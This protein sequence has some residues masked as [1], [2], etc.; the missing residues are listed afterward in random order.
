MTTAAERRQLMFRKAALEK[1]SSP[2]RLDTLMQ[3]TSP[4]GWL[5]IVGIGVVIALVILWGFFG[6]VSTKVEGTGILLRGDAV[7]ALMSDTS[8]RVTEIMV[9]PG[10]SVEAG[11]PVARVGQDDLILRIQNQR[12][13]LADLGRQE[14]ALSTA[15]L[16]AALLEKISSQ[17]ELVGRGLLTRSALMSTEQQLS[18]LRRDR[19][20]RGTRI[21]E[22][23]RTIGELEKRLEDSSRIVTP[24]SGRVLELIAD[25]GD[26]IGPGDRLFTLEDTSKPIQAVMFVAAGEGK[27]VAPGMEVRVSP[28]TVKRE[29]YGFIIGEVE[30]VSEFPVTPEGLRRILRNQALVEQVSGAGAPIEVQVRLNRS[31]A[32]P[33]GFEWSSS[34]G[35]PVEIF[36]GTLCTGSMII[37]K[38]RPVSYVLPIFRNAMGI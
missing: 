24:Y 23:Q 1:L 9:A 6:E 31:P 8:G 12:E 26:L 28:S 3:I 15:D 33:S 34:M 35:P 18:S 19:A 32:T 20:A 11:Q 36:S 22:L 29:E 4:A 37:E 25:P 14:S 30:R 38:K 27:K 5:A 17:R 21:A 13:L 2:E 10:D 16:E 7:L